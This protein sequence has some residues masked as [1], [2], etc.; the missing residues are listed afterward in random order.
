M[1]QHRLRFKLWMLMV[2]VAVVALA[3]GTAR[4]WNLRS[5]YLQKAAEYTLEEQDELKILRTLESHITRL[6]GPA[7]ETSNGSLKAYSETRANRRAWADYY[8]HLKHKYRTAASRPWVPIS[9][10][11][12]PLIP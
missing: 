1:R 10:D 8:G 11:S 3:L 9:P 2:V 6:G 12:P 4:I 7:G 5:S